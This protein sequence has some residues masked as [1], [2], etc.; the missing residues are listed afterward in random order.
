MNLG[1]NIVRS[2]KIPALSEKKLRSHLDFDQE[3]N[4]KDW[5]VGEKAGSR[6]TVAALSHFG[7]WE[8]NAQIAEFVKPR[9]AGCVYQALRSPLM[10]DLV[11]RDRR[12]RGVH[13]FDRKKEMQ[14]AS[15]LLKSGGVV[16][17]L[18]DQHAGNAGIWMPLFGK[19]AS[20]SPLAASLAQ[21]TGSGF[22]TDGK[23]LTPISS[24]KAHSVG[25]I[26]LQRLLPP[27]SNP[28]VSLSGRRIG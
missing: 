16:G 18:T 1:A 13:T 2:V 9:Q 11:N 17:V 12:S 24:S 7:N 28:S 22:T 21:H 14:A 10:D 20:T 4:W 26:F 15:N 19:L 3:Q 6:G 5:V 8:I 27:I 23:P 25:S